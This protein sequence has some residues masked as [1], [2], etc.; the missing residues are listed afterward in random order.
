MKTI[1]TLIYDADEKLPSCRVYNKE[2]M[3]EQFEKYLDTSSFVYHRS[4]NDDI[5]YLNLM[6]VVGKCNSIVWEGNK[7]FAE[8]KLLDTP[9]GRMLQEN[10]AQSGEDKFRFLPSGHGRTINNKVIDYEMCCID[11]IPNI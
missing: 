3:A 1:R 9:K 4:E 6:D 7:A 11:L 8:I 10:M 2:M 5:S